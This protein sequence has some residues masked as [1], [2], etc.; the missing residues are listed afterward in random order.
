MPHDT[1]AVNTLANCA[2][3]APLRNVALF[4]GLVD[5]VV[6]RPRHL[7]GFGVFHGFSG[8]GK[9]R[10]AVYAANKHRAYYVEVGESWTRRT[11]CQALLTELGLRAK[12]SVPDMV[13]QII[14][15]LLVTDRPL[16]IDEFDHV[17]RRRYYELVRE[18]H[19][20]AE[21]PVV[22]I[23]EEL[24][25]QMMAQHERLHNR[26]L[27][28]VAAQPADGDDAGQLA[29]LF[30]PEVAIAPDLAETIARASDGRVRRICVNIERVR[31]EALTQ[32]WSTVD[33]ATWGERPLFQGRPPAR[34]G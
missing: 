1:T 34:R 7:P 12:G 28:W 26:V 30:A 27:D 3:T 23:G 32:G 16:I 2:T 6:N 24:L 19:D 11:F 20:K 17:V 4:A 25:P 15:H 13:Q 29:R 8:Y 10:A 21:A 31:Q 9:T 5:Q 18:I 22:V 14:S 33:Q